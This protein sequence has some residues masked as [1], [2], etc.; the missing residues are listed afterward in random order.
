VNTGSRVQAQ[1]QAGFLFH[2]SSISRSWIHINTFRKRIIE[3]PE[4]TTNLGIVF[5][6]RKFPRC[7]P[8]LNINRISQPQKQWTVIVHRR[9]RI[10]NWEEKTLSKHWPTAL[11][12]QLS[13]QPYKDTKWVTTY[14]F[15]Y[16]FNIRSQQMLHSKMTNRLIASLFPDFSSHGMTI[17]LTLSKQ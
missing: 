2:C 16:L 7:N 10:Y 13:L 11:L 8:D 6:H 15:I 9:N 5:Q 4:S 3:R 1:T 14:L 12:G 17:S